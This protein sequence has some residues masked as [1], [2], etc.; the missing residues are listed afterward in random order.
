MNYA[1]GLHP[2]APVHGVDTSGVPPTL[3]HVSKALELTTAM[4][5]PGPLFASG[6]NMHTECGGV[7]GH[8][9]R[10]DWV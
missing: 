8:S 6:G 2:P 5:A 10:V 1:G 9:Q 3:A 7:G 4:Q